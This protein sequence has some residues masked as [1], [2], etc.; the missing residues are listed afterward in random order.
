MRWVDRK[1]V[2]L[3]ALFIHYIKPRSKANHDRKPLPQSMWNIHFPHLTE[4]LLLWCWKASC[5][6]IRLWQEVTLSCN[7]T[8]V[9]GALRSHIM[10]EQWLGKESSIICA[11]SI[12]CQ[13]TCLTLRRSK[14]IC[15]WEA[16]KLLHV[17]VNDLRRHDWWERPDWP[18]AVRAVWIQSAEISQ[19]DISRDQK[20]QPC[21]VLHEMYQKPAVTN[22]LT[23]RNFSTCKRLLSCHNSTFVAKMSQTGG[24][25]NEVNLLPFWQRKKFRLL[26]HKCQITSTIRSFRGTF[27]SVNS[28]FKLK[29][30]SRHRP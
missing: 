17:N 15:S 28:V 13:V 21:D 25:V 9:E 14:Q 30:I 2:P 3:F 19:Y 1:F 23:S 27:S 10:L 20:S 16:C 4:N 29:T 7:Q 26:F 11:N 22:L 8:R 24:L 18:P 12:S 6:V 5:H